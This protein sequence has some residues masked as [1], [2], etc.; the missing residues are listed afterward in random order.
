M[1]NINK[2]RFEIFNL[3][4][5]IIIF[6]YKLSY[7]KRKLYLKYFDKN[8]INFLKKLVLYKITYLLNF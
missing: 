7:F 5:Y 2:Y 8:Y 3:F 6:F 4:Y 1:L